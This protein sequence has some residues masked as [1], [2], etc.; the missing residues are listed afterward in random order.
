MSINRR[1]PAR[2]HNERAIINALL[3]VG[4]YVIPVSGPGVPDLLVGWRGEWLLMEVKQ[5][6]GRLTIAQQAFHQDA[7]LHDLSV[8]II[9]SEQEAIDA[10][11]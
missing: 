3:R 9:H 4:A 10:L 5:P 2:D 7:A 1:A 6:K 11:A 8:Y